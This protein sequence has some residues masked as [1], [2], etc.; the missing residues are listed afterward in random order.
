MAARL[1]PVGLTLLA[2]LLD[3]WRLA[4]A[5][6]P[7]RFGR[8]QER[9]SRCSIELAGEPPLLC[10]AVQLDQRTASVLRLSLLAAAPQRQEQQLTLVGELL[11]ESEPMACRDGRCQLRQPLQLQLRT[12]SL[13]HFDGRGL[14]QGLPR[15]WVGQGSCRLAVD[16][17][18]CEARDNADQ[19]WTVEVDFH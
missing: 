2:A 8:W 4:A 9:P 11:P 17:I 12:I 15:T 18:S 6:E 14:A 16:A 19:Q 1:L 5:P 7:Q 10:R 13:T 3:P